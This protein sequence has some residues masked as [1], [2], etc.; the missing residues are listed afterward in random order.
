MEA[1]FGVC[2][3]GGRR[4]GA[5][6]LDGGRGAALAWI[7]DGGRIRAGRQAVREALTTARELLAD[8]PPATVISDRDGMSRL[9]ERLDGESEIAV[10]TEAD[11]FYRY[12][13]RVCLV[14]LTVGDEDFLI[15]PLEDVGLE[16]LAPVFADPDVVKV[17]HDGE[18]DLTLFQRCHGMRFESLFDTRVA[19]SALGHDGVG[20]AAVLDRY[21]DVQLDK[22]QQRS[23]WGRRPLSD[24]QMGY[25]RLDTHFLLPLCDRI[26]EELDRNDRRIVHD[27][28]V[29]RLIAQQPPPRKPGPHDWLKLKGSRKL[30]PLG[31]RVLERAFFARE[32]EAEK[33]DRPPFKVLA[34]AALVEFAKR[35]PRS[36]NK[37]MDL[38][39]VS[40]SQAK[41]LYPMLQRALEEAEEQG[42]IE[43]FPYVPPKDGTGVL[44][45]VGHERHD[46]LK[47][48][49]KKLSDRSGMDASLVLHRATLVSIAHQAPQNRGQ[50]AACEGLCEWQLE[51][52][53]DELLRTLDKFEQD[54]ASGKL[55]L[56][57]R[58]RDPR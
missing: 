5:G 33:R 12:Q 6:I 55:E 8:L 37:V 58:R 53:G 29:E 26:G 41:R 28:E 7:A 48:L 25:A 40:A 10:D 21:F 35:R 57:R 27:A 45:E 38:P 18:F 15:D 43:R 50:L 19:C 3:G 30:D 17:L 54:L 39:Q 22:S 42:P 23:D 34:H 2:G 46:R 52:W 49:R 47:E 51:T 14:Q 24:A 11:S 56:R 44:D 4:S 31:R 13:E 20:L 1:V 16:S 9:L 36:V 32:A